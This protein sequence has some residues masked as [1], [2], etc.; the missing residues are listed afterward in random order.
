MGI[1]DF[2]DLVAW[3]LSDTLRSE[4][5][6][7]TSKPGIS[8]DFKYCSDIRDSAASAPRNIAEGFARYRPAD[9]ARFLEYAV[10]SL[11]ETKTSIH[12]GHDRQYLDDKLYSRLT[13]LAGAAERVTKNL[14]LS[15][16]RQAA[17]E[18][19]RA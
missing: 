17:R 8:S 16:K 2:R 5:I 3:Q 9:F 12:D 4:V 13:N 14:M 18:R 10:A 19:R 7:F 6:E 11:A 15:K 1:R